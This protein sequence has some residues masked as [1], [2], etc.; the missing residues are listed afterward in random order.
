MKTVFFF[1]RCIL[2]FFRCENDK[3]KSKIYSIIRIFSHILHYIFP[4]LSLPVFLPRSH[5]FIFESYFS[6]M[7]PQS[8]IF[9]LKTAYC[10]YI[11]YFTATLFLLFFCFK[12]S[13]F[14]IF[15]TGINFIFQ[16]QAPNKY[17]QHIDS[18]FLNK[19]LF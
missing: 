5:I 11:S 3:S 4:A 17:S 15:T 13:L 14:F 7:M 8:S 16:Q 9:V 12:F 10:F 6:F 2:P 19:Y 1:R 18:N